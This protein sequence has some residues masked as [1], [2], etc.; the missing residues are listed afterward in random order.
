[1]FQEFARVAPP[2]RHPGLSGLATASRRRFLS[3]AGGKRRYFAECRCTFTNKALG[4]LG[5]WRQREQAA[6]Q[7]PHHWQIRRAK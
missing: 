7:A 1:M 3:L 6:R 5:E 2:V 4:N